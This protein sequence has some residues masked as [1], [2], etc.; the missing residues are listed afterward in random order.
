MIVDERAH[1][2][3]QT[4]S[5]HLITRE[6]IFDLVERLTGSQFLQRFPECNPETAAQS[7]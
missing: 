1:P 5:P 4:S 2:A 3:L 7:S 6:M